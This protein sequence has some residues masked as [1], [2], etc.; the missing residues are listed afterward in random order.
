MATLTEA[1]ALGLMHHR[2][3][4]LDLAEEIYRRILAVEPEHAEALH[5]AGALAYEAGRPMEAVPLIRRAVQAAPQSAPYHNSLALAL[6][7]VEQL[8]AAAA[9]CQRALELR[10][11]YA[12][13]YNNLG[14]V[15]KRQGRLDEAV[16]CYRHAL[17]LQPGFAEPHVNLA[18]VMEEQG[19]PFAAV[20]SY[21]QALQIRPAW[22]QIH[23]HLL[24]TMH[25]CAEYSAA[26]IYAEHRRWN[27][28]HAAPLTPAVVQHANE[29]APE[30]RL[31]VGYVSPHFGLH[32]VGRFF[33]PLV[34]AHDH[35]GFEIF[36]YSSTPGADAITTACQA[37]ADVWR[38]T[39]G[40]SDAQLAEA[41][42]AD[43]IDILVDLAM[44][45]EG[46]RLLVFARRPAPVQLTYLAYCST[47]GLDAMQYR[48]SDPYLDPPDAEL[49]YYREET[50]RLPETYWCYRPLESS[51]PVKPLPALT[52]GHVTFGCLNSLCKVTDP[53]LGT[54]CQLLAVVPEA[55]LL[56]HASAGAD[57]NRVLRFIAQQG[58]SP[59][60]LAFVDVLP[61]EEY[62]AVYHQIDV[63][64]DPFPYGGGTTTCDALWMGVPV[65]SLTGPTAVGRGGLSILSNLKLPELVAQD[66]DHYVHIAAALAGDLPRLAELRAG[67]RIRMKQSPLTDGRRFARHV[68][69]AYRMLWRR[70]CEGGPWR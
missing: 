47:T 16:A 25:F 62:L 60:R 40:L 53:T 31:R 1:L 11:D 30:R 34:E 67:L 7:A 2:A 61:L 26:E 23:S 18:I 68:E 9:A 5:L 51:P 35:A 66:Q 37:Y 58:V 45:L 46:S 56:L 22:P 70:W 28:L 63:A 20:A 36:C 69:A 27:Q 52:A 39:R 42:R 32:P 65:V 48:L 14:L 64:L 57:R 29:R 54:W 49:M 44:H 21:R 50:V 33:L 6:T 17:E 59:E 38:E 8:D 43:Q 3:G 13:A 4:R 15:R 10:P 12:L 41:I 19:Q 55:R 24:H